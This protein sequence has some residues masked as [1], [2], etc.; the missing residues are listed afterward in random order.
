MEL[1]GYD[2]S[3]KRLAV[4]PG[5]DQIQMVP[6]HTA[7]VAREQRW[8]AT[9]AAAGSLGLRFNQKE[10]AVDPLQLLGDQQR[11]QLE[12]DIVPSQSERL[13]LPESHR[14]CNRVKR[15]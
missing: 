9:R 3:V 10:L 4:A 7:E 12:V 14:Q 5:K 1:V 13:A 8:P 6:S 15:L 2:C 11:A